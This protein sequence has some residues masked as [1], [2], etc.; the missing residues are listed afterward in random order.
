MHKVNSVARAALVWALVLSACSS[1]SEPGR[2]CSGNECNRSFGGIAAGS[3]ALAGPGGLGGSGI[4]MRYGDGMMS[5]TR[6]ASACSA[7]CA[8]VLGLL[9]AL[10]PVACGDDSHDKVPPKG[11]CTGL[12]VKVGRYP[13][14][15][16]P[17]SLAVK[18]S[19]NVPGVDCGLHKISG[20]IFCTSAEEPCGVQTR[21]EAEA[22]RVQIAAFVTER[23]DAG[24]E[25][26]YAVSVDCACYSD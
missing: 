1:G 2:T 4:S 17:T 16:D 15:V 26:A 22:V 11:G 12:G 24:T 9:L 7:Q 25:D 20:A 14:G 13:A 5:S 21:P 19:N 23:D 3:R 18:I 10:T 8:R 6:R